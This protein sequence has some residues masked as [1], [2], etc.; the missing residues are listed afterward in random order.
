MRKGEKMTSNLQSQVPHPGELVAEELEA[1]NWT[2]TD[3]AFILGI[4]E[5]AI[6]PIIRGRR[7]V[8]VEMAKALGEAFD[9]DPVT[10]INLQRAYDLSRANRPDTGI[11]RRAKIQAKYPIRQMIRRGW[12][13]AANID[14]LEAQLKRFFKLQSIDEGPQLAYA[15]HKSGDPKAEPLQVAWLYRVLHMASTIPVPAFSLRKLE[16]AVENMRYLLEA[17]EEIRHVPRMLH[18][19]GV[20]FMIVE[21]LPSSKIDGVCLWMDDVPTIALSARLDRNDNAWF[22]LRHELEHV[23]RGHGKAKQL[24]VDVELREAQQDQSE[25][26]QEERVANEAAADFCVPTAIME[27]FIRRKAPYFSER[28]VL[29]LARLHKIHPGI[30]VGQLHWKTKKYNLLR[31]YLARVR[32]HLISAATVDG[33]GQIASISL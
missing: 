5:S 17:P 1:R 8:T 7:S 21:A 23:L 12:L 6:N 31:S 14:M 33:W 26:P 10:F 28:D 15:A 4:E 2:Q 18:E 19:C 22:V 16:S 24:P 3:L 9:V 13:E 27:D 11:S 30:V 29:G 20:R 25:F 32:T